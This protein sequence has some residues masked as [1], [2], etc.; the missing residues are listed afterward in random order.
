MF[1]LTRKFGGLCIA[2]EVQTGFGRIGKEVWGYK[3][4]GV[5]PDIVVLAKGIANGFPMAAVVSRKE[6]MN[7]MSYNFFN[8]YGGGILQCRLAIETLDILKEEKLSENSERIGKILLDG[9][10]RIQ[11][12]SKYFG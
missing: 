11:R 6:I 7:S 1:E 5:Q 12:K 8:T 9:F 2:D 3:W 10:N 4:Q